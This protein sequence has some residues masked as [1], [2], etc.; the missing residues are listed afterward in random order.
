MKSIID[1]LVAK[2]D[3][4]TSIAALVQLIVITVNEYVQSLNG[5]EINYGVLIGSLAIAIVGWY[6][7]K[8]P[9]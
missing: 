6:T 8:K 7:G 1:F 4:F 3:L 5:M 9:A 2:K